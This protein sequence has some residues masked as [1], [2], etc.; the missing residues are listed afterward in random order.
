MAV[1]PEF[2]AGVVAQAFVVIASE[3]KQSR[4]AVCSAEI[5]SARFRAPRN[6]GDYSFGS[7]P[8]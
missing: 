5:A 7:S 1:T 3:A 6:D 2:Q 8:L 4:A